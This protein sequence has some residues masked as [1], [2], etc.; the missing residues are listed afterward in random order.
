[1]AEQVVAR[2]EGIFL[3]QH[4]THVVRGVAGRVSRCQ[5]GAFGGE[6]LPVVDWGLGG[7]RG[8]FVDMG[9]EVR[10]VCEQIGDPSCMVCV[11]VR[12]QNVGDGDG[13]A[14]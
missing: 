14:G 2:E 6:N 1:M 12:E 7:G 9:R 3:A 5:R 8:V 13:F 4:E 11:P 10:G